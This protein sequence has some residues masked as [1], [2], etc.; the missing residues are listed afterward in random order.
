MFMLACAAYALASK[1]YFFTDILYLIHSGQL[2]AWPQ[3]I[4]WTSFVLIFARYWPPAIEML[5]VDGRLVVADD[6]FLRLPNGVQVAARDIA[7]V[8]MENRLFS[9]RLVFVGNDGSRLYVGGF[10]HRQGI[11]EIN[12]RVREIAGSG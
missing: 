8:V 5:R 6:G 12:T 7:E 11:D 4:G 3:I 2:R 10:W 1:G 9:K